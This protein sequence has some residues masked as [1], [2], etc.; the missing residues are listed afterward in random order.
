MV[1]VIAHRSVKMR[2]KNFKQHIGRES[3]TPFY[4]LLSVKKLHQMVEGRND[5]VAHGH[6]EI[7]T[8][9][10]IE[11]L[12]LCFAVVG[13]VCR[14]MQDEKLFVLVVH[15]QWEWSRVEQFGCGALDA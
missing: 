9:N 10:K 11:F 7:V 13:V 8:H 1:R 14:E 4:H 5:L 3:R 6:N 2:E 12:I 15:S